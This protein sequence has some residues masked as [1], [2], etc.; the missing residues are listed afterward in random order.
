MAN[1]KL[2][3]ILLVVMSFFGLASAAYNLEL[4]NNPKWENIQLLPLDVEDVVCSVGA[5]HNLITNSTS[6]RATGTNDWTILIGDDSNELP[7]MLWT[8]PEEYSDN[9][10]YL[11][12]ASLRIGYHG[13]LIRLAQETTPGIDVLEP[14]ESISDFDT[15]FFISDQSDLVPPEYRVGIRAHQNTYAWSATDADDFIIYEYWIVNVS[16][17]LLDSVYIAL[18]ADCDISTA[19]GGSGEQAWSRDDLV[20][21]YR[22]YETG[23]FISYMYDGDNPT[24]PGNDMGGRLDPRE[25]LG[26]IGSRLLYCPPDLYGNPPGSQT[27]HGWWDWNSDPSDVDAC[28]EWFDLMSDGIWLSDPPSPHDF[29]FFQKTG[30]FE[31]AVGDSIRVVFAFGIGNGLQGMRSNLNNARLL[32]ENNYVYYNLPPAIPS[33]F[34]AAV[35]DED[36]EF[37]WEPNFEDDLMGYNLYSATDPEGPFQVLNVAPIDTT[38]YLY[39]PI[40]RDYFY[41][42]LTAIDSSDAESLPTDMVVVSTLPDPPAN[43]RA[44]PGDN[45]VMLTWDPDPEADAYKI[46]RSTVSGGPYAL[47]ALVEPPNHSYFDNDVINYQTYYYV[48]TSLMWSYESPYS[49]EVEVTPNPSQNGRVLLVDDY[50][51]LEAGGN[52]HEYQE[53]RRF[54][55]RWGVYNFDYDL[56]VIAEQGMVD[57]STILNYQAVLFAS[58]GDVGESDGTWWYEVGAFDGG[59][60]RYYLENGGHLLAVGQMILPWIYN[61]NPPYPGDFE[62]DWFGIDSTGGLAWDYWN[63]FTWAIAAEPGYP[64]SMKIDVAKNPDQEDYSCDIFSL[65]P[66]ADTLFLKGLNV[67]GSP[68]QDYMEP[69]GIIY[70]PEGTSVTSLINFSLYFMPAEDAH[71]TMNNILRDEFGCTFYEDP[72]PLPP[73]RVA[74]TSLPGYLLHLTWDAIDEDD[75]IDI[76]IYRSIFDGPFEFITTLDRDIGEYTDEDI[77]PAVEYNYKLT[78]VDFAGQEG[79]FSHMVTEFGGRP[80]APDSVYTESGDGWVGLYWFAPEDPS[81]V[82]F[83]IYRTINMSGEFNLI[84]TVPS[85]NSSYD[86]TNVIN[87]NCYHYYLTSVS[88]FD[89]ESYPSD[90]VFAY[91]FPPGERSGILVVNGVDWN[92]YGHLIIYFYENEVPTGYYTD[93]KFWDLFTTTPHIPQLTDKIIGAGAIPPVFFD[94]FSTILW[95]GNNYN[96]DFQYWEDNEENIIDFLNSGGNM[97]LPVRYGSTWFFDEL[98]EYASIIEDS[99]RTG[100]GPDSLVA[101]HDSLTNIRAIIGQSF[102]EIPNTFSDDVVVLYEAPNVAPGGHA[103]FAVLPNGPGGGGVFIYIAGRPYRWNN[104]D[105]K[106]NCD[107]MLRLFFDEQVVIDEDETVLPEKFVLYQNYPN[108]FN[109]NTTIRFGLPT[110]SQVKL[111]IY[112]ILGRLVNVLMD[113]EMEAGYHEIV[114]NGKTKSGNEAATGVYFYKLQA[115]DFLSVKKMLILK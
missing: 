16:D 75:V 28:A 110:N 36:I 43:L 56:W 57:S 100:L 50:Q 113:R 52:P 31:I 109:P 46:Y 99:W 45:S 83:N 37:S 95:I 32:F 81:I 38:Y 87:R 96:G 54:Y 78:C 18:H 80:Q 84:A 64:D 62:F 59:V 65:R 44:I 66:G 55:Q 20:S 11:Y 21:Y 40:E 79:D 72:A 51:E 88:E 26:Y 4:V 25:S 14:P 94:A 58:D 33:N 39:S 17:S 70:R 73:W 60:L 42:Y 77:S 24:I 71:I 102:W 1:L 34:T 85:E 67:G 5:V 108:P 13:H 23:E 97:L 86:D 63:D 93:Y 53:R 41:F 89:I 29:R 101:Q 35:L 69:V 92:T 30:P 115:N 8:V 111:E 27:G 112:D 107:V 103:G 104:Q 48:A 6:E 90:T 12:F 68:P 3:M 10:H 114:W 22:D 61:T 47:I 2:I 98:A 19:E 91:P 15:H 9:N 74:V 49:G 82:S 7:S 106:D 105:L 76:N